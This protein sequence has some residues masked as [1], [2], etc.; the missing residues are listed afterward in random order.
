MATDFLAASREK[1]R[2][3][4]AGN[5]LTR[6]VYSS[7]LLA[8]DDAILMELAGHERRRARSARLVPRSLRRNS[9]WSARGRGRIRHWY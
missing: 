8:L 5:D 1:W 7:D 4:P 6:P 2:E 9:R 3:L